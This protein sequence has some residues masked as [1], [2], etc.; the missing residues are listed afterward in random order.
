MR[1]AQRLNTQQ[2][3]TYLGGLQSDSKPIIHQRLE[4]L[5]VLVGVLLSLFGLDLLQGF[6]GDQVGGHCNM[7][8]VENDVLTC[9]DGD[10][11]HVQKRR[12]GS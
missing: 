9:L 12:G 8:C 6:L 11:V 4:S 10:A 2:V 5:E 3:D 1:I 7:T